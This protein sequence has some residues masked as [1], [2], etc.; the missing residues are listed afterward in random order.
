MKEEVK[1]CT[2]GLVWYQIPPKN[3][4]EIKKFWDFNQA[5]EYNAPDLPM[6]NHFTQIGNAAIIVKTVAAPKALADEGVAAAKNYCCLSSIPD[7]SAKMASVHWDIQ[8]NKLQVV[9][10]QC[11]LEPL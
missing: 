1:F 8:A 6:T 2:D 5:T 7:T 9:S 10:Q 11:K 3:A 4:G